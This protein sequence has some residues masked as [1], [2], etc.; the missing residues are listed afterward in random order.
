MTKLFSFPEQA[1]DGLQLLSPCM[2]G[3]LL[4]FPAADDQVVDAN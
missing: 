1:S 2:L 3:H 4:V